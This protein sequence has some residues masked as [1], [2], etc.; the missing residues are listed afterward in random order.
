MK[1]SSSRRWTNPI[2]EISSDPLAQISHR[3]DPVVDDD[4]EADRAALSSGA[5]VFTKREEQLLL[6]RSLA[7]GVIQ[8][9][10]ASSGE[11]TDVSKVIGELFEKPVDAPAFKH[12]LTNLLPEDSVLDQ[13][14]CDAL[15]VEI[16]TARSRVEDDGL[17]DADEFQRWY[18]SSGETTDPHVVHK[19]THLTDTARVLNPNSAFRS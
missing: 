18:E 10:Q 3:D 11:D 16:L 17:V 5:A 6:S 4:S 7:H 8:A 1:T 19:T 13:E 2:A 14:T 15:F 9:L 12:I